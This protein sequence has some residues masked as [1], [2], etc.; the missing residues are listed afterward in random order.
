MSDELHVHRAL[1][2]RDI[3]TLSC[4]WPDCGESSAGR[5]SCNVGLDVPQ[6]L[7]LCRDHLVAARMPGA[8]AILAPHF[9]PADESTPWAPL[10]T[11][12]T[13]TTEADMPDTLSDRVVR[14]IA[15]HP[16]CDAKQLVEGSGIVNAAQLAHRQA[17]QFARVTKLMRH[18]RVTF[19]P[20]GAQIP[21]VA[22]LPTL[23]ECSPPAGWRD[24]APKSAPKNSTKTVRCADYVRTHPWCRSEQIARATRVS[25]ANALLTREAATSP[26]LSF[27]N[28]RGR[29][30]WRMTDG[31]TREQ[32]EADFLAVT[33]ETVEAPAVVV[34]VKAS[35]ATVSAPVVV[36]AAPAEVDALPA[37]G[38]EASDL[39][40]KLRAEVAEVHSARCA[41][42]EAWT[43]AVVGKA[44][45][46]TA[47]CE[48]L[49]RVL[50]IQVAGRSFDEL[51]MMVRELVT[52]PETEA[53]AMRREVEDLRRLVAHRLSEHDLVVE[54]LQKK[55]READELT[56]RIDALVAAAGYYERQAFDL[57]DLVGNLCRR[58]ETV[59][60][61][62]PPTEAERA[63]GGAS[64]SAMSAMELLDLIDGRVLALQPSLAAP[65]RPITV[66]PIQVHGID[67][68]TVTMLNT[69]F[70]SAWDQMHLMS[71][72]ELGTTGHQVNAAKLRDAL[73]SFGMLLGLRGFR[74]EA[75]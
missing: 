9:A 75:A 56:R 3:S 2:P 31:M 4:D 61:A 51:V 1:D 16:G 54:A 23:V 50:C 44:E 13:S 46:E 66:T 8:R 7:C 30:V 70:D 17:T 73:R 20:I 74:A 21:P 59:L 37:S 53:D 32:L 63:A 22:E 58:A 65:G 68:S 19:W 57:R 47:R 62:L 35:P 29:K 64:I 15:D 45:A 41:A 10:T 14:Y 33:K 48:A 49:A 52:R 67:A 69:S 42:L 43:E 27:L 24:R 60:K 34:P 25:E 18:G 5:R 39:V 6:V 11:T 71:G 55:G 72:L 26:E 40:V 38:I 36:E 28:I 12:P